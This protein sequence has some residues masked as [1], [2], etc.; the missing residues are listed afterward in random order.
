MEKEI[1]V[2]EEKAIVVSTGAP[3]GFEDEQDSDMII[4]RVKVINLLS[5][6]AK[7]KI[8]TEGDIINS[9]TLEKLNDKKFIPVFKYASNI[10]WKPRNE[11]GGIACQ[12]RNGK[13]ATQSDGVELKCIECRKHLFDNTKQGRES[14][15][16]C[17]AYINFFGFFEGE[18]CP[19]IL[20]FSKTNAPEGKK[21]YS[22]AKVTM[23]NMWANGYLLK[24]KKMAKNGNEW[25]NIVVSAA[26]AATAEDQAYGMELYKAFSSTTIMSDFEEKEAPLAPSDVSST[27][28]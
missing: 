24:S 21:L 17:T 3:L 5:P 4:P 11:G 6:E 8:A 16:T 7:D 19:I 10:F 9:L 23:Q 15:P 26:G 28:Y 2:A 1:V 18:R 25:Y 13:D 22:L 27:E 14:F 20:N 12:A